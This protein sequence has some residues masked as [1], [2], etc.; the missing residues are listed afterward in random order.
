M[1]SHEFRTPLTTI[2]ASAEALEYYGHKWDEEKK[3]TYLHRI[4]AT[5]QHMTGLLDNILMIGKA[6][7][8]NF[9]LNPA[10]LNLEAFCRD[11]IED[12]KLSVDSQYSINFVLQE[13]KK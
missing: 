11:V 7:S 10:P 8:G 13:Q 4:Q 2:L 12:I 5:A 6:E 3:L 1:T 9:D